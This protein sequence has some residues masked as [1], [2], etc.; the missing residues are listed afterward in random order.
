M[1]P[2]PQHIRSVFERYGELMC[3]GDVEAIV[4]L[5]APDAVLEDPVGSPPRRGRAEIAQFFRDG[6]A[7]M[8]GP[9]EMRLDGAVRIAGHRAAAAYIASTPHHSA[10]FRV[11]TLDVVE[12]DE[13]G[14]IRSFQAYFGETNVSPLP[15]AAAAEAPARAMAAR[16]V[17]ERLA[18]LEA[19]DA[20][21]A[22]MCR[23][24]RA[25]DYK[26][27]DELPDCFTAD[28]DAH[29]GT[30]GWEGIGRE[31]IVRFLHANESRSEL[32]LSHF[33]H[34]AEITVTAPDAAAGLFK[35]EDWVTVGGLTV[36]RGFG[37]YRMRFA[38]G[39]DG[40]WRI[41]RLRLQ[42]DYREENQH[43]V[44]GRRLSIT[45]ALDK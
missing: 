42:Y 20:V 29:W 23:Y 40:V 22:A 2:T 3:R 9:I 24:W 44:D 36:M 8:G 37:Q 14:L 13:A 4:Q 35:L 30:E 31:A 16:T 17:E 34:N 21:F 5:F 27:W 15:P 7:A 12:F 11:E 25:L 45:P 41:A 38:R 39:G 1:A 18:V 6:I 28:A 33:G 19:K 10:P 32:R 26:Q 43:Y